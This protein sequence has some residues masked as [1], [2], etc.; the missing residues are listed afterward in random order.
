MTNETL[1]QYAN[2]AVYSAMAVLTLAMIAYAPTW[3]GSSRPGR[4]LGRRPPDAREGA[5]DEARRRPAASCPARGE[6]AG[7]RGPAEPPRRRHEPADGSAGPRRPRDDPTPL[8]ARKAAGIA[9]SRRSSAR[10][11]CSPACRHARSLGAPVAAAATCTSSPWPARSSPWRSSSLVLRRTCATWAS[12]SSAPVLLTLGLGDH[13]AL[14]AAAQLVPALQSYW[15]AI[16]VTVASIASALFA[17]G[18]S[19]HRAVPRPGAGSPG[20]PRARVPRAPARR[21]PPWS[22]RPTGCT[23]SRS[24]CGRSPSSPGPSGPTRPGGA[25]GTGTPRRSGPSSS[26]SSTRDTCTPGR[27]AA[28]TAGGGVVRH[29]RL[30]V[31]FITSSSSTSSSSASTA[32][33]ASEAGERPR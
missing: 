33:R 14:H 12:S 20:A 24:R 29:R 27:P 4:T 22:G 19:T 21:P 23:S 32:T 3:P 31:L 25:T 16:H 7:V 15:L 6:R 18:F 1:A 26:G 9:R 17:L 13:R 2:L 10:P 30:R 28:G 11:C 8:R 5:V